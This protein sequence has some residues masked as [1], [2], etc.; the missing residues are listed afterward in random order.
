MGTLKINSNNV[1][2]KTRIQK[3]RSKRGSRDSK[4]FMVLNHGVY[5]VYMFLSIL[6]LSDLSVLYFGLLTDWFETNF[7]VFDLKL[8]SSFLCQSIPFLAY[9]FSHFSSW[10]VVVVSF[11]RLY[12]IYHPLK[13]CKLTRKENV[14]KLVS[15][16]AFILCFLNLTSFFV[17]VLTVKK[18]E[19]FLPDHYLNTNHTVASNKKY[20]NISNLN[21][22]ENYFICELRANQLVSK[23][24]PIIDKFVYC[25]IPFVLLTLINMLIIKKIN[26]TSTNKQKYKYIAKFSSSLDQE[27]VF[28]Q[29]NLSDSEF[30][31]LGEYHLIGRKF[32]LLLLAKSFGFLVLCSPIVILFV[33]L[34]QIEAYIESSNDLEEMTN[35]YEIL[36]YAQK[37]SYLLMYLNHSINF[38]IYLKF[39]PRFRRIVF[40]RLRF[41]SRK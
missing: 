3:K 32:T 34:K 39:S 38:F 26:V 9:T 28:I 24:L 36:Y 35:R 14:I 33:F 27:N 17:H 21:Y 37:T 18:Y 1:A 12:A 25:L 15:L 40:Q 19:D 11:I 13:A 4:D 8:Y 2:N 22:G 6:S 31:M 10:L 29:T 30:A 7:R 16:L 20:A 41:F 23:I 5:T